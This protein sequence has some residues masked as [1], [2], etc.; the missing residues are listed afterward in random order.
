M[1][2]PARVMTDTLRYF[3]TNTVFPEWMD[4]MVAQSLQS[5]LDGGLTWPEA[6]EDTLNELKDGVLL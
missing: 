4:D 3:R 5:K 2:I 6:T 1:K